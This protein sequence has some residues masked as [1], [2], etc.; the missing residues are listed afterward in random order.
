[1]K[2][3]KLVIIFCAAVG[4]LEL[5]VPVGGEALL[6]RLFELDP[7][8]A[9]IYA[10]IFVLPLAMGAL[11]LARPPML[12]WQAGVALAGFVLGVVRFRVWDIVLH[13]TS[14][15]VHSVLRLAAIIGG[16]VA[17]VAVLMK[18]EQPPAIS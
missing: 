5:V 2:H 4:L 3:L 10:A 8:E 14:G 11:A 16:T 9:V 12:A 18:P 17:A 1:V 13:L 7:L 6:W 15:D